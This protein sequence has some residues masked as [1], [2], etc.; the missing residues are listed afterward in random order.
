VYVK[1]IREGKIFIKVKAKN[2]KRQ[3][4]E[5]NRQRQTDL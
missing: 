2:I 5:R 3:K 1:R 4:G